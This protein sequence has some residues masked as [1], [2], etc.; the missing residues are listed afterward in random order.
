[1]DT[2]VVAWFEIPV[3]DMD[4]ARN[5][6]SEVF[7]FEM[8]PL[9][10]EGMEMVA[11]PG[12]GALVKHEMYTVGGNGC[13]VYFHSK[14]CDTELARV[15]SAGGKIFQ[16]KKSIGDNGFVGFFHDTEGNLIGLHSEE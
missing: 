6:Y 2:N 12:T 8:N 9:Q 13:L 4:R 1:M 7:Q 10:T 15:E 16:P 11:F 14:D 5:F 3:N